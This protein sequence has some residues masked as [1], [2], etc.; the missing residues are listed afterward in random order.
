[1]GMGGAQ[2]VLS[3]LANRYAA[4]GRGVAVLTLDGQLDGL[5]DLDP[6]VVRRTIYG[7]KPSRARSPDAGSAQRTGTSKHRRPR[8]VALA[9]L[10]ALKSFLSYIVVLFKLRGEIAAL[11][12]KTVVSYIAPTNVLCVL[13]CRG[14]SLRLVISERNDPGRQSF[15]A[16]WDMLRKRLYKQADSITANSQAALDWLAPYVPS[17]KLKLVPNPLTPISEPAPDDRQPWIL[18]VGRLEPQ[19]GHA[20]LLR[21]FALIRAEHPYWKLVIA[22]EGPER[23]RLQAVIADDGLEGCAELLGYVPDVSALMGRSSIYALCS[24]YEGTSNAL[25]EA[26]L[27]GLPAIVPDNVS[28]ATDLVRHEETGLVYQAGD[29]RDLAEKLRRLMDDPQLGP[30]T[31]RRALDEVGTPYRNAADGAWDEVLKIS[32]ERP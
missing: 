8:G 30:S 6:R 32:Q 10:A 27:N 2:R 14:R 4:D 31:A 19:K 25:L 28:S 22:G 17:D 3:L 24:D 26:L 16:I 11:A 15:G 21:A 20:L 29:S 7:L 1:M 5:H 9:K 12:P 23:T 18:A 13:A